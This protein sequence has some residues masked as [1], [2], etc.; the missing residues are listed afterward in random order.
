MARFDGKTVV[1]TGGTSGIG[2]AAAKRIIDEGGKV[3]VTGRSE[4]GLERAREELPSAAI[5]LKNDAADPAQAQALAEEVSARDMKIDGL[6]LNAGF[7]VLKPLEETD[8]AHFDAMNE[9]NVRGVALHLAALKPHLGEGASVLVTGSVSPYLG[10]A[11]GAVYAGTKGAVRG[12]VTAWAAELAPSG[13]RVNSLAPG[14]IETNFFEGM[15]LTEE[16][17]AGFSEM[18]KKMVAL[19]RFGTSEEAAAV[20]CFLLSDDASYVTGS[21]YMVDGGMTYR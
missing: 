13:I 12:M 9:V 3:M 11:G 10:Q 20:A 17:I 15:G 18:I 19:G 16:Q 7:G 8:A 6:F 4:K 21:E 5:V 14:P 1:I 2:L